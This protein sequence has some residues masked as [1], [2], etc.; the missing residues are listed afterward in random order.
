ME[1]F[2]EVVE[3]S[4]Q[5]SRMKYHKLKQKLP[6]GFKEGKCKCGNGYL[7]CG[8]DIGYCVE[9]LDKMETP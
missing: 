9:C 8:N 4:R 1:D 6:T 2:L 7:Y 3:T 5:L